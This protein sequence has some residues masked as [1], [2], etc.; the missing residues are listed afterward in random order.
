MANTRTGYTVALRVEAVGPC[1]HERIETIGIEV[2]EALEAHTS[3]AVL[4]AA[5]EVEFEPAALDI[6]IS[7][8]ASTPAE[9]HRVLADVFQVL[10]EHTSLRSLGNAGHSVE[11]TPTRPELAAAGWG[12]R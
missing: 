8:A 1:S 12:P 9:L 5:T 7:V 6:D 10:D 2:M 11:S 3:D 4:G